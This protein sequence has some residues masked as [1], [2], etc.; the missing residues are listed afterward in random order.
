MVFNKT[1][2]VPFHPNLSDC[3]R[4][5][6]HYVNKGDIPSVRAGSSDKTI[7]TVPS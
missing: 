1:K 2:L 4:Q 7:K 6:A 5:F 3:M